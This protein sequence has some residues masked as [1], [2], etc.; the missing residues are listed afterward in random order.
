MLGGARA[1]KKMGKLAWEERTNRA[2]PRSRAQIALYTF[3]ALAVTLVALWGNYSGRYCR[4]HEDDF[5]P[6]GGKRTREQGT[7]W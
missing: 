4:R 3:A 7:S 1:S 2:N 5:V 6:S